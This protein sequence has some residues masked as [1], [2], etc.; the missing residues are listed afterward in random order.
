MA[1][2]PAEVRES[3]GF[4]AANGKGGRKPRPK[5]TELIRQAL[6]DHALMVVR[7]HFRALGWEPELHTDAAGN[8]RIKATEIEGG[9][10]KIYGESKDG[11]INMTDHDDLGAM[12]KAANDLLDRIYGRP[13]QTTELSGEVQGGDTTVFV[14]DEQSEEWKARV[15]KVAAD[16]E[17]HKAAAAASSNG[18]GG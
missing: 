11:D 12:M 1:H 15:L 8:R 10:I 5:P 13:K 9:G 7:P 3:R 2:S 6:E 17:A 4:I 14:V 18:A 16:A